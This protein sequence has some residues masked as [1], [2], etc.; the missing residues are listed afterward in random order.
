MLD[1]VKMKPVIDIHDLIDAMGEIEGV[2][3]HKIFRA[4]KDMHCYGGSNESYLEIEEDWMA[5]CLRESASECLGKEW[6][7]LSDE[8]L[9]TYSKPDTPYEKVSH[10]LFEMMIKEEI[11]REFVVHL[12]W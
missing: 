12:W 4:F 1:I 8:E 2:E 6:R 7:D 9:L 5:D 10:R 11:P 3:S